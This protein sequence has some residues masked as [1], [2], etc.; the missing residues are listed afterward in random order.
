M[1][2]KKGPL[3]LKAKGTFSDSWGSYSCSYSNVTNI[4]TVTR[5]HSSVLWG[6]KV[7][8]AW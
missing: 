6:K 4:M 7:V 8:K 3:E 2:S 5:P 1:A